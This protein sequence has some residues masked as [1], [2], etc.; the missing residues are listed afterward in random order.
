[1]VFI[2]NLFLNK[3]EIKNDTVFLIF[4]IKNQTAFLLLTLNSPTTPIDVTFGS[5]ELKFS[6]SLVK[7]LYKQ[8]KSK[9]GKVV[10]IS[11]IT[12][13]LIPRIVKPFRYRLYKCIGTIP[14]FPGMNC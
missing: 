12:A 1:M 2:S 4:L 11:I 7:Q 14:Q 3:I 10:C 9:G 5:K 6:R 13:E 8:G